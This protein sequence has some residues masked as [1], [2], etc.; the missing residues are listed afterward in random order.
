M[1]QVSYMNNYNSITHKSQKLETIQM[2]I[3]WWTKKQNVV[4]PYNAKIFSNKKEWNPDTHST[5]INLRNIMVSERRQKQ[6][7]AYY[8]TKWPTYD[9]I[10]MNVQKPIYWNRK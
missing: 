5:W 6:K 7:T 1:H 8:K 3:I 2:P 9:S 4:H 10:Y